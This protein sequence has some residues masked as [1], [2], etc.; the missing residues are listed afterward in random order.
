[1]RS[2]YLTEEEG[3]GRTPWKRGAT[4]EAETSTPEKRRESSC[5]LKKEYD[6]PGRRPGS[7]GDRRRGGKCIHSK[8]DVRWDGETKRVQTSKNSDIHK[9]EEHNSRWG[10]NLSTDYWKRVA[11][12]RSDAKTA[13]GRKRKKNLVL[14]SK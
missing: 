12:T 9:K 2:A 10:M 7:L 11:K 5:G 13:R 3:E 1:L 4:S 8:G 6:A 14:E